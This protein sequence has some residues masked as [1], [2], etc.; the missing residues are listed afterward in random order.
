MYLTPTY[1]PAQK[2]ELLE[3]AWKAYAALVDNRGLNEETAR[4]REE[5]ATA[6]KIVVGLEQT[7]REREGLLA[8]RT[9]D[10]QNAQRENRGLDE[11]CHMAEARANKL[12][13]ELSKVKVSLA[14]LDQMVSKVNLIH[15]Y[16][17]PALPEW[18]SASARTKRLLALFETLGDTSVSGGDVALLAPNLAKG[19]RKK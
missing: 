1:T 12:D 7:I 8:K 10:L 2:E 9:N 6:A 19:P 14:A 11:L 13:T 17:N 16:L 4:L 5:L 18:K 3:L 15:P